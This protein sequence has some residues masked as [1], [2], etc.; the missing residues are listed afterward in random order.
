MHFKANDVFGGGGRVIRSEMK[1]RRLRVLTLRNG[2]LVILCKRRGGKE[3]YTGKSIST[4]LDENI[5]VYF[6]FI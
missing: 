4:L 1:F 3:K 2:C 5:S 6:F